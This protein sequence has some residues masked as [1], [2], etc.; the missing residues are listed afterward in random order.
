VG[1]FVPV[2]RASLSKSRQ[3]GPRWGWSGCCA[4]TFLQ[5]WFNL[6][7][8]GA[9][10]GAVRLGGD[11]AVCGHGSGA[12]AS[13]GLDYRVQVPSL[14]GRA[15][16]GRGDS[17]DGESVFTEPGSANH[18]RHHR[19]CDH[20]SCPQFDQEPELQKQPKKGWRRPFNRLIC[21]IRKDIS[22]QGSAL[23]CRACEHLSS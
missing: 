4:S 14:A 11:A 3:R 19:R 22:E 23:S 5:Q 10:R 16:P 13:A 17:A 15:R 1:P 2:D 12:G 18:D 20:H 7:G 6:S 21:H 9:G 8:P